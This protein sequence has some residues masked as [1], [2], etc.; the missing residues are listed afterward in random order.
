VAAA[1]AYCVCVLVACILTG[2]IHAASSQ[3]DSSHMVYAAIICSGGVAI[4]LEGDII[5]TA[6]NLIEIE[7]QNGKSL[8]EIAFKFWSLIPEKD[9]LTAY[10]KYLDC[11]TKI[12]QRPATQ[13]K[14][15]VNDAVY[16]QNDVVGKV[17]GG[18]ID[19]ENKVASFDKIYDAE[20]LDARQNV[21]FGD[22]ILT[23]ADI[24]VITT[25]VILQGAP[26]TTYWYSKFKIVGK[27]L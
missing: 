6:K 2:E 9:R 21:E 27:R 22:Y 11:L 1:R 5:Q 14:K 17:L 24:P 12:V 16:Q 18:N 15:R 7:R 10:E 25:T 19:L 3:E 26:K 8:S 23:V 20:K 4:N 13:D